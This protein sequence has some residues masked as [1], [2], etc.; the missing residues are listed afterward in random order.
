MVIDIGV[1]GSDQKS[2]DS[3]VE[4]AR[5]LGFTGFATHNVEGGPDQQLQDGFSIL[6][7]VDFS[8]RGVKA[9]RKQVDSIRKHVMIVSVKL[10]SV[11]TANWAAGDQRV[12]LL[13]LD[14]SKEKKFRQ[15][16][17]RLAASSNTALEVKFEP[18]LHMVG[19][20]RSKVIKSYRES[21][22]T[23]IDAGMQVILSS[24]AKNPLHMRSPMAMRFIG[25]LLGM[26]AKY[27][28][29]AIMHKPIEMIERNRERFASNH[30]VEGLKILRKEDEK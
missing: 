23:A 9:L 25:E 4:M 11:E 28:E 29:N 8:V 6:K 2:L 21:I 19:L 22:R 14:P 3:F 12:D 5:K 7:R 20:N 30:V 26:E 15:T 10:A 13:V 18:L 27:A 16:T 24:G 17:A 1:Y